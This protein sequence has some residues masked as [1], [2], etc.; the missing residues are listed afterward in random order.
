MGRFDYVRY[1]E[2]A[3]KDQ[4]ILK[5]IFDDIEGMIDASLMGGRA[6]TNA[7]NALEEAYM[8]CGKGIRDQQIMRNGSAPL[9][10]DRDPDACVHDRRG[11]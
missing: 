7:M 6:K 1:D 8:W 10:E 11:K 5:C 2:K 4:A 3:V 9:Q